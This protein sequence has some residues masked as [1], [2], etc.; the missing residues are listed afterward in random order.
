MNTKGSDVLKKYCLLIVAALC[1]F[2]A[3]TTAEPSLGSSDEYGPSADVPRRQESHLDEP[4]EEVLTKGGEFYPMGEGGYTWL[5]AGRTLAI[6]DG[7]T[8]RYIGL[9]NQVQNTFV[10]P[11][12]RQIGDFRLLLHDNRIFVIGGSG[13][14][15]GA[16]EMQAVFTG[17][18]WVLTNAAIFDEQ[19]SLLREFPHYAA[20]EE[21]ESGE[22][23]GQLDD[24]RVIAKWEDTSAPE[25]VWIDEDLLVLN[26]RSRLFFYR[27][28]TDTLTLADD[29]SDWMLPYGKMQAYYGVDQVMPYGAGCYYFVHRNEEKSNNVGSVWYADESGARA[30]FDGQE[31]SSFACS[32]EAMILLDWVGQ[33]EESGGF[34]DTKIWHVRA[35]REELVEL[36]ELPGQLIS[37]RTIGSYMTLED[38]LQQGIYLIGPRGSMESLR[39]AIEGCENFDLLGIRD[40]G[41]SRTYLYAALI[42]EQEVYFLN[43]ISGETRMLS[44]MPYLFLDEQYHVPMTHFV[45]RFPADDIHHTTAVRVQPIEPM[46]ADERSVSAA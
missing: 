37:H 44:T 4:P 33:D 40:D 23:F 36:A 7:G 41:L 29:L 11:R 34:T 21:W 39:P 16:G 6:Q 24:G 17:G 13:N 8:V 30:L 46:L 45:E 14:E 3:C 43:A 38:L 27:I 9:D 18:E 12:E 1:L 42:G 19:G 31:F 26:A 15:P 20:N 25:P 28:S 22:A 35:D 10:L 5:Y 32:S 2:S